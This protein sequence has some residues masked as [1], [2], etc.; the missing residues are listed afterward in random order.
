MHRFSN[1]DLRPNPHLALLFQDKLGGFVVATPLLRGLKEKYPSATLDYFGGER[2]A[3]L[4]A[5]CPYVD[6]RFSLYGREGALRELSAFVAQRET[7]AGP[8]DLA[9]NLDFDP[10]NAVVVALLRPT[11]VVGRAYHPNGRGE[12]PFGTERVDELARPS[13]RWTGDEFASIF[14]DVVDSGFIG[15][16]FCRMARVET[17]YHRTEVPSRDPQIDV[18]RVLIA[19][20]ATRQAKLWPDQSWL[21]L[22][23]RC[24]AAAIDVGLLG[25]APSLQRDAYG[26][27]RTDELLLSKTKVIDLRGRLSL[28][29]VAG[30]L[31]RASACVTVD[32][33]IMHLAGAVGTPTV[34]LF[35]ASPWELW[36]PRVDSLR[37]E[38]PTDPC[39]LCR[40]NQFR[41]DGCLRER[42]VCMESIS[43]EIVFDRLSAILDNAR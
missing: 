1:Q 4:E 15:E 23:E 38:L 9:I 42:H 40:D 17:D 3:E 6:A 21:R 10:L 33:G 20:G 36:A 24:D 19:T 28:P 22:V 34:A 18:P 37:V 14:A 43:P 5:A 16:I 25:A 8:Y 11:Y 29:E 26:S 12:L 35:G 39:S 2:T 7:L 13:T 30:A 32:N 27:A 41:N 31:A